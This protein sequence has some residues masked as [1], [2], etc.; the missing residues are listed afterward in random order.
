MR[1]L[2][3]VEDHTP[4]SGGIVAAWG[5]HATGNQ[6]CW[7]W[8]WPLV[9]APGTWP[10]PKPSLSGFPMHTSARSVFLRYSRT[11]SVTSRTAVY[12]PVCTVVWQGVGRQ[13][14]PLCRSNAHLVTCRNESV[15]AIVNFR[16][17][18]VTCNCTLSECVLLFSN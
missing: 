9:P 17:D 13:L 1:P 4:S 6:H 11:A 10:A 3:A 16:H 5:T 7:K 15:G 18:E 2:A 14:P 12:G 8:S